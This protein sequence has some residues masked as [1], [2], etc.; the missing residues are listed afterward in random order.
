MFDI[1]I[2]SEADSLKVRRKGRLVVAAF[3][4]MEKVCNR[5]GRNILV[6]EMS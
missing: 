6:Y 4:D 5:M 1:K 3:M 2:C